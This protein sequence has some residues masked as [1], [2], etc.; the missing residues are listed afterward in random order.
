MIQRTQT[1]YLFFA[2]VLMLATTFFP[3]MCF[4]PGESS[5]CMVDLFSLGFLSGLV[6]TGF[7][8]IAGILALIAIFLYKKRKL[9]IKFCYGVLVSIVLL[10]ISIFFSYN[11]IA[12]KLSESATFF[13]KMAL[14]FPLIAFVLVV[15]AISGIK[16]DEKIVN[17]ADRIR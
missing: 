13:P 8:L 3:V 1:V 4:L 9:Q 14:G 6:C 12:S 2:A 10:Y 7:D 17:S 5:F 16:N 11:S 15:M